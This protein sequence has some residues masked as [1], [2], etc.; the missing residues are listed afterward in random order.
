MTDASANL[1]PELGKITAALV[2]YILS[3]HPSKF[4]AQTLPRDE[5]M[6]RA[7]PS[8]D[9]LVAGFGGAGARLSAG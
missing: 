9:T 3:H 6:L 7:Q 4:T 5:S 8:I 1:K 2:D